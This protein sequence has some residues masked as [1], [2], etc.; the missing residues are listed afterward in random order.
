M[1]FG[2]RAFGRSSDHEGRTLLSDIN[3]LIK[4][5]PN[6]SIASPAM[7]RHI[8]KMAIYE[9]GRRDHQILNLLVPWS[10]TLSLQNFVI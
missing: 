7:W 4:E 1:V 8:E 6:T 5:T 2:D 3:V 9:P 10:W